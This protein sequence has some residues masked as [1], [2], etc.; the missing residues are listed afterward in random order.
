MGKITL[1][2][3]TKPASKDHVI[4]FRDAHFIAVNKPSGLLCVPGLKE[5]DNLFDRVKSEFASARVVHRLDMGTSG[6]VLF[7]LNKETQAA[8]GKLFEQRKISKIYIAKVSGQVAPSSGEIHSP[9]ICDWPARPK[10]KIDWLAGK[11]SSTCFKVLERNPHENHSR[12]QLLPYTG[13]SHQL[14]VHML[15]IGHP[16]LGDELYNPAASSDSSSD[17]QSRLYLHAQALS[18]IHPFN[19]TPLTLE[20]PPDF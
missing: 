13:R 15:Q 12:V 7:A 5:P 6:L 3:L 4:I 14:R 17:S 1:Y 8:M 10:Q 9:L 11:P 2:I 20:C 19:G 16:I 18:F